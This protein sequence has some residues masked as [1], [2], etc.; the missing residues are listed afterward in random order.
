M[1]GNFY[2]S[3]YG[4]RVNNNL[5]LNANQRNRTTVW[6]KQDPFWDKLSFKTINMLLHLMFTL[7]GNGGGKSHN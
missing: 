3:L 7:R 5:I 6:L 2:V 4:T 1:R